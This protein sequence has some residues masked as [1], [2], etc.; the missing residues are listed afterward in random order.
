MVR[1]MVIRPSENWRDRV[2]E[3]AGQLAAGVL[4]PECAYAA[5]LFPESLLKA[6]DVVL[7]AFEV[8][9]GAL[10]GPSDGQVFGVVES[11]VLALNRINRE[12][13][14]GAYETGEREELCDY[15]DGTLSEH[16]I[17]IPALAARSGIGA[18]EITDEWRE[19]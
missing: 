6:T 2:A 17:D 4:E 7:E 12:H 14:G 19:W 9:V 11:V 10:S 18:H 5:R 8:E 3:E 13:G 1:G 16:G 15:I